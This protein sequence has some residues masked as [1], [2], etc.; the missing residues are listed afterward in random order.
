VTVGE[1]IVTTLNPTNKYIFLFIR[2]VTIVTVVEEKGGTPT[3]RREN[4]NLVVSRPCLAET[5]IIV[6]SSLETG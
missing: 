5:V 3:L 4:P 2:R 1:S 6:T